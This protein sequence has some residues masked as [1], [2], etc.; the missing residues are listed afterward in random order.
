MLRSNKAGPK[1][2]NSARM[3]N[4]GVAD[5]NE[6]QSTNPLD[7]L[8]P[9][10]DI[11]RP[12]EFTMET[13][14]DANRAPA[15]PAPEPAGQPAQAPAVESDEVDDERFKGKSKRD[16][17]KSYKELESRL[18]QQGQEL[19]TMKKFFDEFVMKGATNP[20]QPQTQPQA[21]KPAE[22]VDDGTLINEVLGQPTSF[23]KRIEE[24]IFGKLNQMANNHALDQTRK[25]A[26]SLLQD[27][28]FK[29]WVVSNVPYA[30]RVEADNDPAKLQFVVNMFRAANPANSQPA[31]APAVP[32]N[33]EVRE[34][35]LGAAAV[36]RGSSR[37]QKGE[38]MTRSSIMD[39]M[40]NKPE[41]YWSPEFQSKL[42]QAYKDG[43]VK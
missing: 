40:Q 42:V 6:G 16:L 9:P 19:G 17:H 4:V 21:T 13:L 22:D 38:V 41:V 37:P 31:Q 2:D 7:G 15:A 28:A 29:Q 43:R 27:A 10:I 3:M 18:G 5:P 20:Q 14:P 33:P 24:R 1:T 26:A 39:L 34:V 35:H 12:E 30:M 32:T 25:Q 8:T 23:I 11:P 36:D